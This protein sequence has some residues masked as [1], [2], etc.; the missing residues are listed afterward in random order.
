MIELDVAVSQHLIT[1]TKWIIGSDYIQHI[2]WMI[3]VHHRK[4]IQK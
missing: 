2:Q 1:K 3:G 4:N